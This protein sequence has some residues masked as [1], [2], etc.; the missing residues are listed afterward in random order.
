MTTL[1]EDKIYV[2]QTCE[3]RLD[4]NPNDDPTI[5]ISSASV[6][7]ILVLKPSGEE[8]EWT[9]TRYGS[10]NKITYTTSLTDLDE[11]GKYKMQAWVEWADPVVNIPGETCFKKVYARFK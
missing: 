9:A 8:V 7:K 1:E 2:N 3:F 6:L 4:C 5:D 11:A 10:T